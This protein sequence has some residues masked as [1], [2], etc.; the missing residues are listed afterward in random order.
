MGVSPF[1]GSSYSQYD[2]PE[3]ESVNVSLPN[4]DPKRFSITKSLHIGKF[5]IIMVNY[6]DCTNY[7]GNKVL[8]YENVELRDLLKQGSID[9]HFSNNNQKISPVARFVPTQTGWD[10]AQI[11]ANTCE[12][13]TF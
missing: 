13:F 4:P 6:T 9:P 7:E 1:H 8:M 2:R 12:R 3:K 11:L 5:L 10:M